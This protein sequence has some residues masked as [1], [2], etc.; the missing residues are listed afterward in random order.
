MNV[1]QKLPL[2]N[3]VRRLSRS[4]A[5]AGLIALLAFTAFA[6]S[7]IVSGLQ[8]GMDSL[9]RRLGAD[10]MVVPEDADRSA[11]LESIV[12]QG[13]T[14]YFYMDREKLDE[15]AALNGVDEISSQLFLASASAGCCSMKVQIMGFDPE[16]DFTILPWVKDV[17][18]GDFQEGDVVMGCNLMGEVG[19]T[20][21]FYDVKCRVAAKLEKT[22]T[23]YDSAVFT[24]MN[25]LRM[26]LRASID[27]ELND[28]GEI[29]PDSVVSC[30]LINV[31]DEYEIDDIVNTIN[32]RVEGVRAVRTTNLTSGISSGLS[33]ISYIVSLLIAAVW[34]LSFFVL[35][36]VFALT[37][38]DRR[39][40]FAVLRVMGVSK[41]GLVASVLKEV[42][43]IGLLGGILGV[44]CGLIVTVPFGNLMESRMG[45]P[46]LLPGVGILTLYALVSILASTAAGTAASIV[47]VK[48]I[49]GIDPSLILRE[50]R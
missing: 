18:T 1:F 22:G 35:M 3:I 33:G 15:L 20:V 50:E 14:G 44:L 21:R 34:I 7:V 36:I 47:T 23:S 16:T 9:E 2:Y 30:I 28:Y 42:L 5:L 49:G 38:N 13:S 10:I 43:L 46:L 17:Y 31:A 6:G 48:K 4:S 27:M 19:E 45:L 12:L 37:V 29:D 8:S 41:A 24:D 25:T 26:L 32:V 40:E 11:D 39:K